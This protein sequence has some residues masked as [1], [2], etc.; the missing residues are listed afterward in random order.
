MPE[1]I[2]CQQARLP[3]AET[4]RL[5]AAEGGEPAEPNREDGD[6]ENAGE[7]DRDR[8]AENAQAQ[9]ELRA[10]CARA[11]RAIDPGRHGE[12]Q[13]DQARAEDQLE[14]GGKRGEEEFERRPL[15]DGRAAEI[16]VNR[17]AEIA[18]ELHGPG[19]VEPKLVAKLF[20]L[21]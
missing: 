9:N 8:D 3:K 5:A 7:E 6:K 10:G 21:R 14:A 20:S 1:P 16:A 2:A 15:V 18:H 13:H 4:Y 11:D 17:A 19:C 12:Q